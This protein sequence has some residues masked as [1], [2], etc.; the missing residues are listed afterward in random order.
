MTT[1]RLV[2]AGL[3]L[4]GMTAAAPVL[5]QTGPGQNPNA[6]PPPAIPAPPPADRPILPERIEP[7]SLS[8][9]GGAGVLG[10]I[11][12]TAAVGPAWNV[13]ATVGLSDRFAVEGNYTGSANR[14]ADR[15]GTLVYTAVDADLRYNILRAD[16]APLQPYLA[17]GIGYVGYAGPGGD[18][19]AV[20]TPLG[21]GAE[22][23]IT[24]R[25]K[26]GAR[27]NVRPAFFDNLAQ[28][29]EP[30]DAPAIGGSVWNILANVG[31]A[32]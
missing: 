16:Q 23:L 24:P 13:R 19:A 3:A 20:T 21:V 1:R 22:R 15:T 30:A 31:G 12:G 11:S 32:F 9:E 29:G 6:P 8:V 28:K 17:A 5:A 14:R 10:Y 4:A 2:A 18:G 26:A 7:T 27:F 25:I